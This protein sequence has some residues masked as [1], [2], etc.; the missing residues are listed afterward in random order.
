MSW[1][2]QANTD[3]VVSKIK[4]IL[5][6]HDFT[7]QLLHYYNIPMEDI[8][9]HLSIKFKNL[10][11]KFAEGSG[12]EILLDKKLL[13]KNF[14]ENN[15]HFVIHEFFHWLKRRY[16]NKFYFND[17]EEVQSFVLAIAWELI[18]GKSKLQIYK[19]IYPIVKKHY[20]KINNSK[21]IFDNMFHNALGLYSIYQNRIK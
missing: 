9:N 2:I 16:E 4:D 3:N 12:K 19:S 7:K 21:E 15:F 20:V 13:N 10:E 14:F 6:Q 17:S 11:G 8:D 1:F 5:K 18:N